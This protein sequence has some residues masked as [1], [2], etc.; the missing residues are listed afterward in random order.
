MKVLEGKSYGS[1]GH[2]PGSRRGPADKGVNDGQHR[3]VCV[4]SRDKR[5][6]VIVQEKLDGSN[7]GVV[8][9]G[10][11][12]VAIGRAGFSAESSP[13]EQHRMFARYVDDRRDM[14]AAMLRE[15]D[16][17]CGEWLAM[18]HGTVYDLPHEPFVA[19]D[20]FRDGARLPF[21]HFSA[22]MRSHGVTM[23]KLLSDGPPMSIEAADAALG[24][25]G[26]HGAL[27]MAEGC[28][29]RV[30]RDGKV[31]YLAKFVR[32]GKVDGKY[33][34]ETHGRD[35]WNTWRNWRP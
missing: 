3:I 21:D 27:E 23:P 11:K 4:K 30:E 7:V 35:V 2:L 33:F 12:V 26:H 8:K 17:V 20:L 19:F 31:D 6:R 9:I 34:A 14:F 25:F 22:L 10:G 32:A 28:V 13:H 24:E 1:I 15:G 5:D 29:W 16:R 18:A